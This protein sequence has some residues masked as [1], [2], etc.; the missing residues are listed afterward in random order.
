METSSALWLFFS[1][2]SLTLVLTNIFWARVCSQLIDRLMSRNFESYQR[3]LA[4]PEPITR[5][6]DED[7]ELQ[8]PN[9]DLSLLHSFNRL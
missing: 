3:A 4:T 2:L 6:K 8:N 9:E 5:K 1:L 7:L